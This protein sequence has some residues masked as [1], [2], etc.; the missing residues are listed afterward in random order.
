MAVV[1]GNNE[2]ISVKRKRPNPFF[3]ESLEKLYEDAKN[4]NSKLEPM[5]KEALDSLSKYPLPLETG[6]ECIILKGFNKKL[7]MF[8][9]KCLECHNSNKSIKPNLI[10]ESAEVSAKQIKVDQDCKENKT[11]CP[12]S[13]SSD[14]GEQNQRF[15]SE[16][17][18]SDNLPSTSNTSSQESVT[19]LKKIKSKTYKPAYR[20]GGYAILIALLENMQENP[21]KLSLSKEELIEKAQKHSEESFVRPK[22]E[23]FYTAWSNMSRLISKGIVIKSKTK[24][25]E[26]S[27]T[28]NGITLAT[29]LLEES[30]GIRT[31]NDVIFRSNSVSPNNLNRTISDTELNSTPISGF[32]S[33]CEEITAFALPAGSF[34]VLLLID[35]NETSGPSKKNDPTVAQF[36][37]YPDMLHEYRSLKVGDFTWIARHKINRDQELVLP[38]IVERKRMDDL[39]HSIKDGRF[40]EQ[41]FRLRKCGLKNVIYMVENYGSNSHCGLPIQSLMQSLANTRVQDGFKV[42]LTDSLSHSAR[43]L[44]MMTKRITVEYKNQDLKGCNSEPTNGNL[45]TFNYFNKTSTK[46]KPLSVTETFIKLLLQIKGVSVE[47]A[48]AITNVYKTPVALMKAYENCIDKKESEMMLANLKYGSTKR[49]VGPC[50]SKSLYHMFST[51]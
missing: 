31:L 10:S 23:S 3:Q 49:N 5:L 39:G 9:D 8:L 19:S 38:F 46:S 4:T 48:L 2:R 21:S 29:K 51:K 14:T 43:F 17:F 28:E 12:K 22:P 44:A 30:T 13:K 18:D 24:K 16:K 33:S 37:K 6:A 11:V 7:C 40:H 15:D 47:K 42:H 27:L 32:Q 45:M 20:S 41:K 50:V 25:V 1:V 26:Y 34:E 36:N 35:K